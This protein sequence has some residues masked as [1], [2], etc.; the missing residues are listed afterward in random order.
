MTTLAAPA[1]LEELIKA[2]FRTT[3][4][5]V[6][7]CSTG[8]VT[9]IAATADGRYLRSAG[10]FLDD[11]FDPGDEI[12]VTG[13]ATGGNNGARAVQSVTATEIQTDATGMADEAAGPA[14]TIAMTLP[15]RR[16]FGGIALTPDPKYPWL[17]EAFAPDSIRAASI[18][19][20]A[21]QPMQRMTGIYWLTTHY[22]MGCGDSGLSRLRG[23]FIQSIYAGR[24]LVYQGHA[25]RIRTAS[26]KPIIEKGQWTS[27]ALA[28]VFQ[29]DALNP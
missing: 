8:A 18:A 21:G 6:T 26:P 3:W 27:G 13:Y 7:K 4:G 16:K 17:S 1:E 24:S 19:V 10:S 2:A 12:G 28:W 25:I 29:A 15:S 20:R 22:P 23:K 14:V 9:T 5:A 11:G